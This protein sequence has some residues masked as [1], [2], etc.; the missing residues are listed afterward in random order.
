[1]TSGLPNASR[2][3]DDVRELHEL[4]TSCQRPS[5]RE[6]SRQ[7]TAIQIGQQA[8]STAPHLYACTPLLLA[9]QTRR[10]PSATMIDATCSPSIGLFYL[11]STLVASPRHLSPTTWSSSPSSSSVSS[12][13]SPVTSSTIRL[14]DLPIFWPIVAV[15]LGSYTSRGSVDAILN[16]YSC[17]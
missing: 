13:E 7:P 15:V 11:V 10:L 1:M 6:P 8:S 2:I 14:P 4:P 3:V 16:L 12:S 17:S 9:T 5:R